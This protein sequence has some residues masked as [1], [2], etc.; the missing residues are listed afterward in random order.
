[1]LCKMYFELHFYLIRLVI[2]L[3]KVI[4][5]KNKSEQALRII[6]HVVADLC[7]NKRLM[8]GGRQFVV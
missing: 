2:L 1:M 6:D 8:Y 4:K 7:A 3:Y 5:K